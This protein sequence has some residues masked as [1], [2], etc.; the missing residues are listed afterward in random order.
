MDD[1]IFIYIALVPLLGMLA[2]LIA[3]WLRI[4]SILLLLTF[5]VVLGFWMSPDQILA[6]T[7]GD[8]SLGAKIIL[9]FVSLSVAVI[10]FEG[11]MSLRFAELRQAAGSAVVRLCTAGVA[12]SWILGSLLAWWLLQIEIR[13][14]VLLG[15]VLVVTGPTVVAPLLRHIRPKR[16]IGS[17]LKWEGII[18]DPIGAILA[19]LVFEEL[20][21]IHQAN[22]VILALTP[23]IN[24]IKTLAIGIGFGC[25]SAFVLVNAVKRYWVPDYLHGL[26]FLATSLAVFAVS[27]LLM[28]ESGLV[29]VTVL[30]ICLANQKQISIQHVVEF[31]E[32]LRV[33]LIS[34]LFIVL[35]SRLDLGV[36]AQV[37]WRG[38]MFVALMILLVRPISVFASMW[39]S[40]LKRNEQVFLAFLAP[41]GI[42]AAA[43]V[44]VFALRILSSTHV[45]EALAEDAAILVPAT[46]MLIVGTVAVYGLSAA[47]LARRLGLAEANPQGILFVGAD[48]WI[49]DVAKTLQDAGYAVVLI[50]TNYPNVSA[51]KMQGLPAHCKSILAESVRENINLVGIGRMFALTKNDA[52]NAIAAREFAHMFG[53]KNVFRL[54]PCDAE[55]GER[56]KVGYVAQGRELFSDDWS[57]AR[58]QQAYGR[59]FR[60]KLTQMSHEFNYEDFK[61]EHGDDVVVLMVIDRNGVIT[62]NTADFDL[63]PEADQSVLALVQPEPSSRP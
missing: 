30:G 12:I 37:G 28:H 35:G 57:E 41:R 10:L 58:L 2:Q 63:E 8:S 33:F 25:A 1:H 59:G 47:P 24:I 53:S 46:F 42:V 43:V 50:D 55:K 61:A 56:S 5:G 49:R 36:M 39:K 45:D 51:A 18:I 62:V 27:N 23:A 11:G 34:C 3:W 6:E 7:S 31:N 40:G 38:V 19:V 60:P 54:R 44:S 4:P 52:V 15:A 26:T 17:I 9:P 14:A 13:V 20:F 22:E 29:T 21:H 16:K 32:N 48:S